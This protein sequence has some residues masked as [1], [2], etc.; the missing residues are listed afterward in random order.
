MN[1]A[2]KSDNLFTIGEVLNMVRAEFSDISISKI[3]F[4][5]A[6]GLLVPARTKSGYRK[7]SKTDIEKL[8]Y[9]LRMQ[10]DHYLPLRVIKQHIDAM[11]RGL[12]VEAEEID[13]PKVPNNILNFNENSNIKPNLRVTREEIIT[14]TGISETFLKD[15]EDFGLIQALADNRHFDEYALRIARVIAALSEYGIEPRHLKILKSGTDREVSL[16]KQ[17]VSP[18]ARSKRPDASDKAQEMMKEIANLT[19]QLHSILVHHDL[20]NEII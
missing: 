19:N 7:F 16:I 5:E 13:S 8:N 15:A 12:K 20:D 2:K 11:D 4:L 1:L 6:E 9:I 17:I 18:L 3:R 14:T 10:R